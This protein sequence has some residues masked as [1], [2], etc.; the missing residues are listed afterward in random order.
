MWIPFFLPPFSPT[1][2][3]C[4]LVGLGRCSVEPLWNPALIDSAV[5]RATSHPVVSAHHC[6]SDRAN[7]SVFLSYHWVSSHIPP[8][9]ILL[10]AFHMTLS[11]TMV[12]F[13]FD[14][15]LLWSER[16]KCGTSKRYR[17][18]QTFRNVLIIYSQHWGICVVIFR[19]ISD[20]NITGFSIRAFLFFS[21][22]SIDL[23]WPSPRF[24]LLKWI[25]RC[26]HFSNGIVPIDLRA[27]DGQNLTTLH[28]HCC[29]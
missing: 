5:R 2:Q 29:S 9:P 22:Q 4:N 10:K 21:F 6:L 11:P 3:L 16:L 23:T 27:I 26:S 7:N 19:L 15:Y 1:S 24:V 18:V 20:L 14:F 12:Q 13:C 8:P 25:A 28:A 17:S